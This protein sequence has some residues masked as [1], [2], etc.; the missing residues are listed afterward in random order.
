LASRLLQRRCKVALRPPPDTPLHDETL[1]PDTGLRQLGPCYDF[2][3]QLYDT[4][5]IPP[6]VLDEV[7]E[8]QFATP[9]AYLQHYGIV[10]LLEVHAVSQR[11]RLPEVARLHVGEAQAIQLARELALPLLIEETVGRQVAALSA[12]I[13]PARGPPL[14]WLWRAL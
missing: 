3:R 13:A 8:G 9:Q 12:N 10:D 1:Q 6:G 5:V 7:T 11:E 2:I 4:I 14:S